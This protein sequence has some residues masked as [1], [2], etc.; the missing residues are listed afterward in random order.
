MVEAH[1]RYALKY[2]VGSQFT[3]PNDRTIVYLDILEKVINP[4]VTETVEKEFK[5]DG[6]SLLDEYFFNN[7]KV[8]LTQFLKNGNGFTMNVQIDGFR[9]WASTS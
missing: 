6:D 4:L 7:M 1:T 3:K 2:N 5:R 9:N 8:L